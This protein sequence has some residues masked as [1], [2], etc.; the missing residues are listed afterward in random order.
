[1]LV[2]EAHAGQ[3]LHLDV[4]HRVALVLREVPHLLLDEAD[5]VDDLLRT[6]ETMRSMSSGESRN[7]GGDHLSNF[8]EY[9][10]RRRRR[11]PGRPRARS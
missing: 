9:S 1:V 4:E 11:A 7:D 3:R 6:P 2:A 10:R 5:V 8:S